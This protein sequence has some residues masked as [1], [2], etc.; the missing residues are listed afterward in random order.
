[1]NENKLANAVVIYQQEDG[2]QGIRPSGGFLPKKSWPI[3]FASEQGVTLL[4]SARVEPGVLE[5]ARALLGVNEA[6]T[7]EVDVTELFAVLSAMPKGSVIAFDT[8]RKGS[9]TG[10]R[11]LQLG[12]DLASSGHDLDVVA[13]DDASVSLY[14]SRPMWQGYGASYESIGAYVDQLRSDAPAV[15][16]VS[17]GSG[18]HYHPTS[19]SKWTWVVPTSGQAWMSTTSPAMD[20]IRVTEAPAS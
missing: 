3:A 18:P 5:D 11:L 4:P 17:D 2:R 6:H 19:P 9:G 12:A 7:S 13:F 8:S 14:G 20:V 15:V 1:M 10:D 16:V